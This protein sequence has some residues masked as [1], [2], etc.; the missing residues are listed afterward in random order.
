MEGDSELGLTQLGATLIFAKLS[1]IDP[2]MA[3]AEDEEEDDEESLIDCWECE[4]SDQVFL[5]GKRPLLMAE[6]YEMILGHVF[7]MTRDQFR[8]ILVALIEEARGYD[9]DDQDY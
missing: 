1:G 9:I 4:I 8:E 2:I 5:G 3:L 7:E 6:Q